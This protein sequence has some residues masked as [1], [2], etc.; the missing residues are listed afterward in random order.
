MKKSEISQL[1]EKCLMPKCS[2]TTYYTRIKNWRDPIEALRKPYHSE[3]Y[4][5]R[6]K[7]TLFREEIER[8]NQQPS[9]KATKRRFYQRLYQWHTKEEAIKVEFWVHYKEKKKIAKACYQRPMKTPAI[10]QVE[11]RDYRTINVRYKKEE[12]EV[13]K[14]EYE[15]MIEDIEQKILYEDVSTAKELN[16][17]LEKMIAEYQRFIS[18]QTRDELL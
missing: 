10:K 7:T 16:K 4:K 1:Y 9:P 13:I 14:K 2:R 6:I 18:Y 5:P 11:N 3:R 15:R 12:A 8:Y 17:E